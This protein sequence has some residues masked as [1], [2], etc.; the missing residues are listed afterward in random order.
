MSHSMYDLRV[1]VLVDSVSPAYVL[2]I[3]CTGGEIRVRGKELGELF[4][5]AMLRYFE[6]RT[7]NASGLCVICRQAPATLIFSSG[8]QRRC[9]PCARYTL[10]RTETELAGWIPYQRELD[11]LIEPSP[12]KEPA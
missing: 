7:F 1:G 11:P 4:Q 8:Y 12:P 3:A 2:A 10:T 5:S 9:E 6:Q